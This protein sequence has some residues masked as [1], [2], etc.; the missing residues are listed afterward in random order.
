LR[1]VALSD[2]PNLRSLTDAWANRKFVLLTFLTE[3]NKNID[4]RSNLETAPMAWMKDAAATAGLL[5]FIVCSFGLADV[6]QAAFAA[7]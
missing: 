3:R 2:S 5:A 6:A 4:C 7:I 1:A